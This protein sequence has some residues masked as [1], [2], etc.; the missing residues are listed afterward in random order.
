MP[1]TSFHLCWP[2]HDALHTTVHGGIQLPLHSVYENVMGYEQAVIVG[3]QCKV[4]R[5][6]REKVQ[7]YITH[8]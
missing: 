4:K 5:V 1:Q 8:F 2:R 6:P 3:N 7:E